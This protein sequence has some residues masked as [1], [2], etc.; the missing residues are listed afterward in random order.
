MRFWDAS[1]LIPLIAAEPSSTA[2]ESLLREDETIVVWWASRVECVSAVRR[3][4]RDGSLSTTAVAHAL[5]RL[6]LIAGEWSEVIPSNAVRVAAERSLAVHPLRAADALQLAAALAW[7]R[8]STASLD[9]V[10]LDGR[11]RDAASREGF[12][13]LPER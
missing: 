12:R 3:R 5:G 1:A 7:R 9:F 10:C 2:A 8:D 6:E 13:V 4:D 11:L